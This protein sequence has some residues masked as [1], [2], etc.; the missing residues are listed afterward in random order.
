M[1]TTGRTFQPFFFDADSK[2]KASF[3]GALNEFSAHR[4]SVFGQRRGAPCALNRAASQRSVRATDLVRVVA[5]YQGNLEGP[6]V[7]KIFVLTK[8]PIG[9]ILV[10]RNML[11]FRKLVFGWMVVWL[12]FAGA[13]AAVMPISGI[14]VTATAS[15]LATAEVVVNSEASSGD[16][17]FMMPCHDKSASVKTSLGQ[18]CSHCVLCHLSGA[19]ALSAMPIMPQVPPAHFFLAA[20]TLPHPSFIPDLLIPPPRAS[21]A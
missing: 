18:S 6:R 10:P 19:L 12:P 11:F 5:Q 17:L 14:L 15:T 3:L 21:L 16:N 20:P 2:Q 7:T 4:G 1:S 8:E 9:V 13:I